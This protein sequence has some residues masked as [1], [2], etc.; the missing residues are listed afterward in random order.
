MY[1]IFPSKT[2][3]PISKDKRFLVALA[4]SLLVHLS[5]L[6]FKASSSHE[7]PVSASSHL[8]SRIDVQL[9]TPD[10]A[11]LPPLVP[12]SE[13]RKHPAVKLRPPTAQLQP[14]PVNSVEAEKVWTKIEKDEMDS[15][16]NDLNVKAKPSLGKTLEQKARTMASTIGAQGDRD[17]EADQITQRLREAKIEP[18]NIELYYESLFRKLNSSAAMVK[19]KSKEAGAHLAVV[20]VVLNPNGSVRSFTIQQAG[21]QQTEIA[22][23]KSVVERAAPFPVF[24]TEIRNATDAMILQICIQPKSFGPGGGSFF[25]RMSRGQSCQ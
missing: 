9:A 13:V 5:V 12:R 1:P 23:I 6:L 22:Y 24:P 11:S 4:V 19:N 3:L 16:L 15:F 10:Q 2:N 18:L 8:P 25:S 14:A 21:D 20:R 7:T 17:D